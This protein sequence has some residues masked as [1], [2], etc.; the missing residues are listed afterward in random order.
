MSAW[1]LIAAVSVLGLD[2]TVEP[3]QGPPV[4]GELLELT[5]DQLKVRTASGEQSWQ[6]SALLRWTPLQVKPISEPADTTAADREA[7]LVVQ[8]IDGSRLPARQY[9]SNSGRV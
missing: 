4:T 8:L 1:F 9:T 2:V 6:R 7:G 5:T 3:L